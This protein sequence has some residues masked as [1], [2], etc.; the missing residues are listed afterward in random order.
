MF[1]RSVHLTELVAGAPSVKV[2]LWK[3]GGRFSNKCDIIFQDPTNTGSYGVQMYD[4]TAYQQIYYK[5]DDELWTTPRLKC[6]EAF[7]LMFKLIKVN[8][9][10]PALLS[11]DTAHNFAAPC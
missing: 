9:D 4:N 2:G 5:N 8:A 6:G 3:Y 11:P 1:G 10:T 7:N